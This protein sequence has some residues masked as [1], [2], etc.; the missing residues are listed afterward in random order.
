[1]VVIFVADLMKTPCNC[2]FWASPNWYPNYRH[3]NGAG[4]VLATI[5]FFHEK[6]NMC[7][8]LIVRASFSRKLGNLLSQKCWLSESSVKM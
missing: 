8:P 5:Q 7:D 2:F 3:L 4:Y 6:E 1:M